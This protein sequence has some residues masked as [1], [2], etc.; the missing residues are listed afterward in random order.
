M[1]VNH[2][3]CWNRSEMGQIVCG[4]KGIIVISFIVKRCKY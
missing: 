2:C 3:V 4:G 1:T